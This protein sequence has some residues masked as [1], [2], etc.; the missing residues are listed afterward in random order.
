[1]I[2]I[3]FSLL[4][5]ILASACSEQSPQVNAGADP[6]SIDVLQILSNLDTFADPE[7]TTYQTLEGKALDLQLFAGRKIFLNFWATWCAPCIEEIPSINRAADLLA[8]EDY[9]FLFASDENIETIR[10]F[11]DERRFVGNFIKLNPFFGSYGINAVPSSILI[12][13]RG[14]ILKSWLGAFE[15]DS[16]E[17]IDQIRSAS[18]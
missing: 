18:E 15:W 5:F 6:A 2:K 12:D 8:E 4:L 17:M 1:M 7:S 11:L 16:P 9:V 14:E 3:L 10:L 13:E